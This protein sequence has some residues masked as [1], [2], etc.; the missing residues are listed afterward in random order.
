MGFLYAGAGSVIASLWNVN[1]ASTAELMRLLYTAMASGLPPAK[2][3]RRAQ[4][5][6]S[7]EERWASPYYWAGFVIEG[8]WATARTN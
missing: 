5:K 6:M 2:A 3:L 1:D 4:L 7:R 8:D